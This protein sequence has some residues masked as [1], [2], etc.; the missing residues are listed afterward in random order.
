MTNRE[1]FESRYLLNDE[2]YLEKFCLD[3]AEAYCIQKEL[4]SYSNSETCYFFFFC[5][6]QE[7]G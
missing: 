3:E 2:E 5:L 7:Y 1:L 4:D 6:A